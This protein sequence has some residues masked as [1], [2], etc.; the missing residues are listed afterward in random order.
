MNKQ[1]INNKQLLAVLL[2][3]FTHIIFFPK[4]ASVTC[5][6]EVLNH[7]PETTGMLIREQAQ[8]FPFPRA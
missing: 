3:Q 7:T 4:T 1:A 6:S 8:S 2:T 5:L